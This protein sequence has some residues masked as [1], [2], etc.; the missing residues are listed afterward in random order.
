MGQ[1]E[2][3]STYPL[4]KLSNPHIL[5]P[6]GSSVFDDSELCETD[7]HDL[8]TRLAVVAGPAAETG[9]DPRGKGQTAFGVR[10]ALACG[11][12]FEVGRD[13]LEDGPVVLLEGIAEALVGV[14]VAGPAQVA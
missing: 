9:D 10:I 6:E 13:G 14:A 3:S 4:G 12:A 5:A 11:L 7:A 2:Q 1:D 8:G